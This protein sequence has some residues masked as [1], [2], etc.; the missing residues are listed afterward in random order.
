MSGFLLR[1]LGAFAL[2]ALTFNPTQWNYTHWL[3]TA[4]ADQTPLIVLCGLVLLT[5]YVIYLR[6]T[7]RSIGTFGMLLVTALVAALLWVLMDYRILR[8]D[9]PGLNTW[10]GLFALSLVLGTGLSWS[11]VRRRLTGQTD[12]DDVDE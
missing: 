12:V 1:W 11:R 7:L 10:I 5:V 8:L 3:M 4:W 2:L 9:D 6:A